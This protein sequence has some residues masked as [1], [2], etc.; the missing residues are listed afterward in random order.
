MFRSALQL[1]DDALKS[2]AKAGKKT[3]KEADEAF[4]EAASMLSVYERKYHP[5]SEGTVPE[6]MEKA[7][8]E[9]KSSLKLIN[10]LRDTFRVREELCV[11][12][13]SQY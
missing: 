12:A 13:F 8:K 3:S 11:F 7:E 4:N 2:A 1:V 5:G 10:R 9:G 6:R